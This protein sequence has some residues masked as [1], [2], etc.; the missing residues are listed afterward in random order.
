MRK[1]PARFFF[2]CSLSLSL[3]LD[4]LLS[5]S[6]FIYI[7][8][9]HLFFSVVELRFGGREDLRLVLRGISYGFDSA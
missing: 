4:S 9:H 2:F 7:Q 6:I 3:S 1:P 5:N 8:F